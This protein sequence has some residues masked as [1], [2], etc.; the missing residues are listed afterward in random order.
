MEIPLL[1]WWFGCAITLLF[2]VTGFLH[3]RRYLST[4]RNVPGPFTA[5]LT[6]CW[7]IY[8]MVIKS[9]YATEIARQHKKHGEFSQRSVSPYLLTMHVQAHLFESGQTRSASR[10]P[11]QCAVFS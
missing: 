10:I 9:D 3:S 8:H 5:S 4:L 6:I 2:L 1:G 7:Q 11:M